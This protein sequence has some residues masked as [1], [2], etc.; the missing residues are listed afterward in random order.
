MKVTCEDGRKNTMKIRSML[1]IDRH[2]GWHLGVFT[3]ENQN[4]TDVVDRAYRHIVAKELDCD[5][6]D[7]EQIFHEYWEIYTIYVTPRLSGALKER[8]SYLGSGS[9]T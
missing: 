5:Y 2:N 3:E 1:K 6:S 8:A 9:S 7:V 4:G